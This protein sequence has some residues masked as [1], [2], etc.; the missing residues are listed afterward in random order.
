[1]SAV[2]INEDRIVSDLKDLTK[3]SLKKIDKLERHIN[4]KGIVEPLFKQKDYSYTLNEKGDFSIIAAPG[5]SIIGTWKQVNWE[6]SFEINYGSFFVKTNKSFGEDLRLSPAVFQEYGPVFDYMISYLQNLYS[7]YTQSTKANKNSKLLSQLASR[8]IRKIKISETTLSPNDGDEGLLKLER[9]I[10]GNVYLSTILDFE[11]YEARC[12]ELKA[13]L[14]LLPQIAEEP[15]FKFVTYKKKFD[16]DWFYYTDSLKPATP[17]SLDPDLKIRMN[18]NKYTEEYRNK[19][20][21]IQE[22]DSID[23]EIIKTLADLNFIFRVKENKLSFVLYYD[24]GLVLISREGKKTWM[25]IYRG[26]KIKAITRDYEFSDEEF[27]ELIVKI[28]AASMENGELPRIYIDIDYPRNNH[29]YKIVGEI[30]KYFLPESYYYLYTPWIEVFYDKEGK[31][32]FRW[33]GN[34]SNWWEVSLKVMKHF[35]EIKNFQELTEKVLGPN[36]KFIMK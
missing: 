19:F 2:E 17:F 36:I 21:E 3:N 15:F 11:N 8:Y 13:S 14:S 6:I 34:R 16:N 35:D 7:D 5:M 1:M 25:D 20:Y 29:F 9:R 28:A 22:C 4:F 32:G 18:Y 24:S 23:Q 10:G 27:K 12:D 33:S 30:Y 31:Y 26:V